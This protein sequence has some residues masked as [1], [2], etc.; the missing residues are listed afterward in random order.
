MPK[1]W[2]LVH[3]VDQKLASAASE[4]SKLPVWQYL[5]AVYER[6]RLNTSGA[7]AS[8]IPE[9]AA[10]DP[11]R[12]GIA[13]CTTDG[14]VYEIGDIDTEF[15][16][17]SISKAIIYGLALEDHG[18]EEVLRKIGVEPSGDAFNSIAFDERNNRPFNPMVNA[19]AIAASALIRG[20]NHEERYQRILEIFHR[21]TGRKLT[22]DESVYRSESATGNR[23]RAIAYLELNA[24]M[25]GGNVD[26]HLDLYFRQCSL[27]VTTRDLAIIGGTLANGGV[28][29]I[30]GERALA[31]SH[32]RA[33]LS[34]MNSC[35][36]YDYAG[37]WQFNIGL[38]AK[39]GVGGGITA[40]L[41]GQLGVGVFSPRLDEVG[42]S[43][44]GVGVCAD[45]SASFGLH[46]FQDHGH[47]VAPFRRIYRGDEVHS[48]RLR[49]QSEAR[50]L[51]QFGHLICVYELQ[52]ELGFIEAEKV[53]RQLIDD[54]G[55][56][57]YFLIDVTRV[58]RIDAIARD[59]L[60]ACR[61][62]LE[63]AGKVFAVISVSDAVPDEYAQDV[64]FPD[65]DVALEYFEN[66]LLEQADA[67]AEEANVPLEAFDV[68][69]QM[70]ADALI[71]LKEKL[72][73]VSFT[74]G[75]RLIV[76]NTPANELFFLTRGRV[77][78]A[79]Q[80]SAGKARR[81][82]TIDAGNIF[83][84]LALFG[85]APRT[86][87]IVAAVEGEALILDGDAVRA[88]RE[89]RQDVFAALLLAVG[90]SLADRL[91]RANGEIRA[92][93]K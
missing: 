83:G 23:N 66:K 63:A 86:A 15:T 51:D 43:A 64:H 38:P 10:V 6:H 59:L 11:E 21:F 75:Q 32:M 42:N 57:Y 8:Y 40:V 14:F 27:L 77:N 81:V 39:S 12:F 30:T 79:V 46:L 52:A 25:I 3:P 26:E 71:A 41:P 35:G 72:R 31:A 2:A 68:V 65:A 37:G 28:N 80:L 58:L 1:S 7:L 13:F 89:E 48:R 91:R 16:I 67:V 56:A 50:K 47:G 17:Q 54:M 55:S 36:M 45:V 4:L 60:N 73:T 18:E 76:Q 78:V 88:L 90:S 34:V 62:T 19:G 29:P 24:G 70:P 69:A 92:L 87:D 20:A 49:R 84:E 93:S 61:K 74:E 22:M 85:S 5:E 44:R 82:S 53:T 33:V 9:L